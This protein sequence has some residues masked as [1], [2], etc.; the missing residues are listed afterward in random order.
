MTSVDT[1]S[2]R[3]TWRVIIIVV[4]LSGGV[5][6]EAVAHHIV[7][8]ALDSGSK[9]GAKMDGFRF[10]RCCCNRIVMVF[11]CDLAIVDRV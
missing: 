7:S 6:S 8:R 10:G 11:G 5:V 9:V 4:G 2:T 3:Q 1:M